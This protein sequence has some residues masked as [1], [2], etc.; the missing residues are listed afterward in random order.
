VA[1]VE[2]LHAIGPSGT[3]TRSDPGKEALLRKWVR[4]NSPT[5][6]LYPLVNNYNAE[7]KEWERE[8]T[9]LMLSS[10]QAR[11]NFADELYRYVIQGGFSGLVLDFESL[12]AEVHADYVSLVREIANMLKLYQ[13]K[14][15]VAVPGSDPV[16][17]Y[18][19]LAAAADALIVMTYDQHGEQD[20]PGP[21]AGQGWFETKLD[22]R[23]KEIDAKKLIISIGLRLRLGRARLGA[24]NI[25][26][27]SLGAS[28]RVEG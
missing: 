10:R 4:S 21:L 16:V 1:V 8:A 19:N 28:G 15:L 27:G 17:D 24:R 6:K 18:V 22:E 7:A 13:I 11:A 20:E 25:G 14:L 9:A 5:L 3:L 23:F 12:P 26:A 2:W